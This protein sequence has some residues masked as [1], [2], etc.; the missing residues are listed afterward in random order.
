MATKEDKKRWEAVLKVKEGLS[1]GKGVLEQNL[2]P[3]ELELIK[4][5]F[6]LTAKPGIIVLNVS[7]NEANVAP[8]EL[9][10]KWHLPEN[11]TVIP[12]SAKVEM[13]LSELEV[14][15]RKEF[16]KELGLKESGLEKLIKAGFTLLGL[17]TFLTAGEKEVRAWTIRKGAKA[18]E[19]AGA[20]HTDFE[21]GFIKAKIVSYADFFQSHG[22]KGAAEA[23]K[24]RVEGKDYV[25]NEGDV[26]EFMFNI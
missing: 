24:V 12:I 9:A 25:M 23:G 17:Q 5:L 18:P 16:L 2:S 10:A 26:V 20:I 4:P 19:A 11:E 14:G 8:G 22:W 6:L 13:E 3:E 21:K 15:E 7:E 1:A